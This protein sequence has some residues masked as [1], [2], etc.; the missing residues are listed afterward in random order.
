MFRLEKPTIIA[1]VAYLVMTFVVLLPLKIGDYDPKYESDGKYNFGY[2][3]MLL[4]IL[5]IPIALS[6]YSINCMVAGKCLIW[7]YVNA[8]VVCLWVILFLTAS[9][10]QSNPNVVEQFRGQAKNSENLNIASRHR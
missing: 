9:L 2:R 7:S 6:L 3:L 10:M 8:V 1:A 4:V 5:L